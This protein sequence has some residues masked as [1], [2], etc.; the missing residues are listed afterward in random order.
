LDALLNPTFKT[1]GTQT[2]KTSYETLG[3]QIALE[4]GEGWECLLRGPPAV[5]K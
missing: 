4:Y 5:G 3:E 2:D 1:V